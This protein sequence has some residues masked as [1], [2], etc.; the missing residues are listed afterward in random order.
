M[1]HLQL[2]QDW[3]VD[4]MAAYTWPATLP[5]LAEAAGYSENYGVLIL[6]T[7]MDAGPAKRRRR[8]NKPR[9]LN[10]SFIMNNTQIATLETFINDTIKGTARFDFPNPRT[11]V[12]AEFRIVP[13]GDGELFSI[14][15]YTPN[16]YRVALS[17]EQMP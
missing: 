15:Y 10:V 1:E 4:N 17:L 12:V 16:L 14:N 13:N 9:V 11:N 6:S 2:D 7:P 5:T 3:W 8:G